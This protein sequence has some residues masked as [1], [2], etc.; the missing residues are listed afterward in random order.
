MQF[1]IGD[2][3]VN[4]RKVFLLLFILMITGCTQATPSPVTTTQLVFRSWEDDL[5]GDIFSDFS[6]ETGIRV[7][8]ESYTSQEDAVEDLMSG[9]EADVVVMDSRFIPE[10]ISCQC[11]SGINKTNVPN[12]KYISTVFRDLSF[13]QGNRYSVPFQ[14]GTT[15]I[16]YRRDLAGR[17]ISKWS[18]LWDPA[19]RGKIGLWEGQPREAIGLTLKMLGYSANSDNPEELALAMNKLSEL[20]PGVVILEDIDPYTAVPGLLDGRLVLSQGYAYDAIE[21]KQNSP[22]I[23]FTLPA[24]GSVLWSEHFIIPTSSRH[25]QEAES[26]L[27]YLLKPEVMAKIVDYNHYA[28]ANDGAINLIEPQLRENP[29]VFPPTDDLNNAEIIF[30][31][32]KE[33]ETY[34][35]SAWNDFVTAIKER[36]P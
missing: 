20:I 17:E 7:V 1:R 28:T 32:K 5:P 13:D 22:D 29:L 10:L 30:P 19:F 12:F 18:D 11:L 6:S 8:Y 31:V 4:W 24:E 21:G 15:G 23:E 26:L 9:M 16:V 33:N 25:K 3:R 2:Y 35:L 36:Q 27:N 14:W 34:L